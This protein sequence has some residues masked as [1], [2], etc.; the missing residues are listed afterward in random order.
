MNLLSA[1]QVEGSSDLVVMCYSAFLP[2]HAKAACRTIE[3][4]HGGLAAVFALA[5]ADWPND[6]LL[7]EKRC[8][9]GMQAA[10]IA[11]DLMVEA[12]DLRGC[13][14]S[15]CMLDGAFCRYADLFSAELADQIYGFKIASHGPVLVFDDDI[16]SGA[17]WKDMIEEHRKWV[18]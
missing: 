1:L 5:D 18:Q 2:E 9:D 13:V 16:R 17:I 12:S 8:R 7:V 10:S 6:I 4:K 3:K 11:W 15:I 14:A